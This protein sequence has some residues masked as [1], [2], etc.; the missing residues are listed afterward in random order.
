[1]AELICPLNGRARVFTSTSVPAIEP[2]MLSIIVKAA[3][4]SA[5]FNSYLDK[6]NDPISIPKIIISVL[7]STEV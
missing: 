4:R 5:S 2:E 1:M 6:S 7:G 3:S